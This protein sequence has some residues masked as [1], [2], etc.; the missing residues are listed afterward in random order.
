MLTI[1][2][3]MSHSLFSSKSYSIMSLIRPPIHAC[4]ILKSDLLALENDRDVL[5]AFDYAVPLHVRRDINC[6][7]LDDSPNVYREVVNLF[8]K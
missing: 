5:E 8:C 1:S 4:C 6:E 7:D 3:T 2:T